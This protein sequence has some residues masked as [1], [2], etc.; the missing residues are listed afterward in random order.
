MRPGA[1]NRFQ[2]KMQEILKSD[3]TYSD[4]SSVGEPNV[5]VE[6]VS[7]PVVSKAGNTIVTIVVFIIQKS[8]KEYFSWSLNYN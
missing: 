4:M 3:S 5:V 7:W 6:N 8:D 1:L 2:K